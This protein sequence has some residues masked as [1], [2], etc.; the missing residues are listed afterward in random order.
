[1]A[2]LFLKG[3]FLNTN[4][5]YFYNTIYCNNI[6]YGFSITMSQG[7]LGSVLNSSYRLFA[8]AV[9]T[10]EVYRLKSIEFRNIILF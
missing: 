6:R 1:M 3:E 2:I 5:H 7:I 10:L 4:S 8:K 9:D